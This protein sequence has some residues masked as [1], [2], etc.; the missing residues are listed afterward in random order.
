MFHRGCA[1]IRKLAVGM[2]AGLSEGSW[3]GTLSSASISR[4]PWLCP[5]ETPHICPHFYLHVPASAQTELIF[6]PV[7]AVFWIQYEKHIDNT[8]MFKAVA[9]K[10]RTFF[11]FPV[12]GCWADVQELGG[13]T[14]RQLAQAGQRTCSI[15]ETSC[16]VYKC[17]L[18]GGV[19][20][21]ELHSCCLGTSCA[22]GCWAVRKIV[23]CIACFAHFII[24]I[25]P[26]FV[27]L[28]NCFYLILWVLLF[29]HSPP[30]PT[31]DGRSEQAA[32]WCLA[33]SH[34]VK[35]RHCTR[36]TL[37]LSGSSAG[38]SFDIFPLCNI[39]PSTV[40]YLGCILNYTI[41]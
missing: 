30:C 8:L 31:G 13:S 28:L 15:P 29:V 22:I 4:C 9:K 21:C 33:A 20:I 12:F 39:C 16:S 17:R 7:A 24:I 40:T 32:A 6:L 2:D 41:G 25:T 35:P 14:A 19:G 1:L 26:S 18:A 27:L 34:W 5:G 11:Q 3:L 23:L 36:D 10:S 38:Q 37:Y